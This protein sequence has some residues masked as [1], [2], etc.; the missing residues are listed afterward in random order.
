M[1]KLFL[2]D[3]TS[4]GHRKYLNID[5]WSYIKLH[6]VGSLLIVAVVYGFLFVIGLLWN[7]GGIFG[8]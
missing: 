7:F 6:I 2:T 8:K 1:V 4:E 3:K 5:I